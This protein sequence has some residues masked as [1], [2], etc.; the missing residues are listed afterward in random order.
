MIAILA[1]LACFGILL[2]TIIEQKTNAENALNSAES[3]IKS[4]QCTAKIDSLFS[5][6]GKEII[7]LMNCTA[8]ENNLFYSKNGQL[9]KSESIAQVEKDGEIWVRTIEHYR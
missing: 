5:N 4:I 3:K 7:S 1:L 8:K 6:S 2:S 9:K